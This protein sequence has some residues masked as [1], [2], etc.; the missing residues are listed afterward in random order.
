L[1]LLYRSQ[2][3]GGLFW[4]EVM[5]EEGRLGWI[6]LLYLTAVSATPSQ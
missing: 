6:P 3:A 5:D 4:M 1:T 2:E